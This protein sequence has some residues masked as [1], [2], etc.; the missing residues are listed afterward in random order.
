MKVSFVI[1]TRNQARFIRKC[2]DS[3]LAQ[4]LADF[5]VVV[6]D[7]LST[8][9]TQEVLRSYGEKVRWISEKDSGQSDALNKSVKMARGEII[10]WINSDDYYASD[11]ALQQVVARFERSPAVDIVYG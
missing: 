10:A 4:R 3:C 9:G 6:V 11:R 2:I 7:G 1:P 8:D 5:E